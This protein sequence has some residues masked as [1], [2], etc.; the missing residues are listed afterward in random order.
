MPERCGWRSGS[1][2]GSAVPD[3]ALPAIVFGAIPL[4]AI[5][6]YN[7][8]PIVLNHREASW[9][10][11]AGVTAFLGLSHAMAAVL[12]NHPLFGD[13]WAATAVSL[14]GLLAGAGIA[15]LLFEGPFIKEVPNRIVWAA[16]AFVSVHSL[17]DGLV[18]GRSFIGGFPPVVPV[19]PVSVAATIAHRFV[20]GCLIIVPALWASWKPKVALPALFASLVTIPAAYL[21]GSIYGAYGPSSLGITLQIGIP[22][23]VAALESTLG[24]F[25]L[26]RALVPRAAADHGRRWLVW[27]AVGYIAISLIHFSVE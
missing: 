5:L 8:R 10:F 21:P 19:D 22:T 12:A 18:L 25:L 11:L 14:T 3:L 15:W 7:L 20:E 4:A 6:L 23:F 1:V 17:G 9:G 24:L 26:V 16:V 27:A 13:A 2:E